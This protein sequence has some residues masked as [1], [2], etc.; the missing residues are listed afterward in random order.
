MIKTEKHNDDSTSD[1]H[2]VHRKYPAKQSK[3]FCTEAP[4]SDLRISTSNGIVSTKL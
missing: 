1:K 4:F 3:F 2:L